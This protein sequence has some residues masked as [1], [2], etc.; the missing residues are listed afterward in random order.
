MKSKACSSAVAL[1]LVASA[2]LSAQFR[3]FQAASIMPPPPV[4]VKAGEE[5]TIPVTVRIRPGYHINSSTPLEDYLIPT[6]LVWDAG[7]FKVIDTEYPEAE[8]VTY[9][10]ST[11]PLSVYSG[12][13]LI[14]AKLKAPANPAAKELTGSLRYQACNDKACL[15]P[16]STDVKVMLR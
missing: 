2:A 16:T 1:A 14:K 10:F 15:A 9:E 13:V 12:E 6:A 5:F 11:S 3:G 4:E 7:D 8:L